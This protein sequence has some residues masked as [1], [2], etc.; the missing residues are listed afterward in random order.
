[1]FSL[2]FGVMRS[3]SYDDWLWFLQNVKKVVCYKKVVIISYK[4]PSL[5][6]SVSEIF[7]SKNHAYCYRHLKENFSSLLNKQN[8][9]G[10]KG[11]EN[12]LEWLDKTAYASW[13]L[14]IMLTCLNCISITSH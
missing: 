10:C 8:T 6:R 11:K 14:I 9:K 4:H 13:I 5:F 3:E 12:A 2:A 1:M 7:G